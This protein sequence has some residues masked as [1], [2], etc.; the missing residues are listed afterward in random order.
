MGQTFTLL[1]TPEAH[2]LTLLSVKLRLLTPRD[3][4]EIPSNYLWTSGRVLSLII[5][6]H[7]TISLCKQYTKSHEKI[8][9]IC[10]RANVYKTKTL[11]RSQCKRLQYDN[12]LKFRD[13]NETKLSLER[14]AKY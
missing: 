3:Q 8:V 2:F 12:R 9:N 5:S 4:L 7:N 6:T 14:D 1:K 13:R 11:S 10:S